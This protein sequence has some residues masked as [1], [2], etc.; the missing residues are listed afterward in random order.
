[1]QKTEMKRPNIILVL[2][3]D[4]GFSDLG[5]TG[6]EIR[7]PH[8]D[9]IAR[10]GWLMSAMYN[11]ARCCPTRAALL[12]GL[13]PHK[14]GIG[15][16]G[17]NLGTPAYQGSLRN[18]SATIAEV[19]RTAG[20][21][22]MMSGK[23]HVGGD[24]WARL[25]D[26]LFPVGYAAAQALGR[27]L[28]RRHPTGPVELLDVAAGSGVWGFGAASVEPRVVP[29]AMDLPETLVHARAW[30]VRTGLGS[31]ARWLE[32]DLRTADLGTAKFDAAV[33]GHICHSEGPVHTP[34]LLRKV[35]RALRPG[36]TLAI[37]EFVPDDDRSGPA[38]PL[39]FALNMLVHTTEGDTFTR[40][41][42]A[43][44]LDEAGFR[45]VVAMPAP[46]PSPLLLA[47]RR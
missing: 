11:C 34:A 12:T 9:S 20:Y 28:A 10:Q 19:L 26:G 21:R 37:V 14:A 29:T 18:D 22:T 35:A 17:A 42:Y 33:L 2:V 43:A 30:A 38:G 4:M 25:V 36:G 44:W 3:D 7:T 40:A 5:C 27:E 1:M 8:I 24:F 45:D 6:S 46:A 31:R 15:H 41:Q 16:M 13:Y 32:G 39:L 23:W 47:T